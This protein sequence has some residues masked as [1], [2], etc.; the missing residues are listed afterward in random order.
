MRAQVLPA[1]LVFDDTNWSTFQQVTV[2]GLDDDIDDGDI[3]YDIQ[4]TANSLDPIYEAID[5]TDVSVTNTDDDTAGITVSLLN[6]TTTESGGTDSF[7]VVLTSQPTAAVTVTLASLDE[8]GGNST[9][10]PIG[11]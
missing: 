3:T 8:S 9:T 5:P 10:S 11:V 7:T 4:I 6:L 2:T 1:Q